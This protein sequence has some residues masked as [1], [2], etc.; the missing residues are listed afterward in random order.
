M[1]L[2]TV[3]WLQYSYSLLVLTLLR[4]LGSIDIHGNDFVGDINPI[5]CNETLLF[6]TFLEVTADCGSGLSEDDA[7]A[8]ELD[9]DC[10]ERC[11]NDDTGCPHET[12]KM[13]C[14]MRADVSSECECFPIASADEILLRDKVGH[15][16][17]LSAEDGEDADDEGA[18]AAACDVTRHCQIC[19]IGDN[20]SNVDRLGCVLH[21]Y[22]EIFNANGATNDWKRYEYLPGS[23][24]EGNVVTIQ[25]NNARRPE[26]QVAINGRVCP[27]C[28]MVSCFD[29]TQAWNVLCDNILVEDIAGNVEEGANFHGCESPTTQEDLADLFGVLQVLH[30][31]YNIDVSRH[32]M[33][34]CKN[35]HYPGLCD[36]YRGWFTEDG[37]YD[38]DCNESGFDLPCRLKNCLF[39]L[40]LLTEE[41]EEETCFIY[42]EKRLFKEGYNFDVAQVYEYY[43]YSSVSET[44]NEDTPP[45]VI[46]ANADSSSSGNNTI[47]GITLVSYTHMDSDG[48]C[49]VSVDGQLC[50]SCNKNVSCGTATLDGTDSSRSGVLGDALYVNCENVLS[51]GAIYD[52]CNPPSG[53]INGATSAT[54]RAL[55]VLATVKFRSTDDFPTCIPYNA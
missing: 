22:G 52:E 31:S 38:C 25:K 44:N 3:L 36:T 28:T 13:A 32:T 30:Y 47:Y 15:V 27:V 26:C 8:S 37:I 35:V 11:C 24:Y 41:Q 51:E 16:R 33:Y 48:T 18:Y 21:T 23:L 7:S 5:F 17:R 54:N 46:S 14:A 2:A 50:A 9:C 12:G 10:C 20:D 6:L 19:G 1:L 29:G 34:N 49:M 42:G 4:I 43:V 40:D 53:E 55:Q 39:C 45:S